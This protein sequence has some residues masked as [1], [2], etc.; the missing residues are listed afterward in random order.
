MH[1]PEV[2]RQLGARAAWRNTS[3]PNQLTPPGDWNVWLVL[4]GR[5]FGKTRSGA[6]DIAKYAVEHRNHRI[7]VVGRT[8][9]DARDTMVEG[10][11][12]LVGVLERY[13]AI[14]DYNKTLG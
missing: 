4:A 3:R 1:S 2:L 6:E 11:S 5:G 13:G 12:G 7:A 10:E 8:Y 14:A 9:G